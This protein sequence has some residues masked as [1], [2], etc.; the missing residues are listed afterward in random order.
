VNFPRDKD[1]DTINITGYEDKANEAKA[2][3]LRLVQEYEKQ[4][5]DRRLR[6]FKTSIDVPREHHQY[7]IGPGGKTIQQLQKRLDCHINIP[8]NKSS[9]T[10]EITG[11]ENKIEAAKAEI[12]KLVAEHEH[13]M[14]ERQWMKQYERR[15]ASPEPKPTKQHHHADREIVGAPWQ[16]N[17]PEQFPSMDGSSE[18][19]QVQQQGSG[20]WS[21]RR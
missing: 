1:S 5:E 14:E 18:P 13:E 16:L 4:E 8:R 3:L 11:Y 10:I 6:S 19:A 21:R 12:E 9:E 7:L 17:N 15:R 20:V 2:E